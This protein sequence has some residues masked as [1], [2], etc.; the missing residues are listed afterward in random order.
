MS[1][2]QPILAGVTDDFVDPAD[3]GLANAARF[4]MGRMAALHADRRFRESGRVQCGVRVIDGKQP[5]LS[6]RW[7]VGVASVS[8]RRLTFRRRGWWV[9]RE[10]PP[11][12]VLNVYGPPRAPHGS[13]RSPFGDEILKL[14]GSIIQVQAQTAVLEW[15]LHHRYQS[16]AIARLGFDRWVV[17]PD[18][19]S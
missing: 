3:W 6:G 13:P 1:G 18:R 9:F 5:G 19:A 17:S 8:R 10:C 2:K 7:Q 14:P 11:I 16:A 4:G 12:Q 15:A